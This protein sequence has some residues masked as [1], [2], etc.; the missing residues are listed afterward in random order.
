MWQ[1]SKT[2]RKH[3]WEATRGW[4]SNSG[5]GLHGAGTNFSVEWSHSTCWWW[6]NMYIKIWNYKPENGEFWHV[7]FIFL[8]PLFKRVQAIT[9]GVTKGCMQGEHEEKNVISFKRVTHAGACV[10]VKIHVC[11]VKMYCNNSVMCTL[12]QSYAQC[13]VNSKTHTKNANSPNSSQGDSGDSRPSAGAF[14]NFPVLLQLN[15]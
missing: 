5:W 10:W 3:E 1:K 13:G 11:V 8:D 6:H 2:V 15:I 14:L 12:P 7:Q 9:K 4:E